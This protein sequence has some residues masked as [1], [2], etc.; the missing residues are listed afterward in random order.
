M[1]AQLVTIGITCFNAADTIPRAINSALRQDWPSCEVIIVDDCSTDESVRIIEEL[2]SREPRARLIMHERNKGVAVARNTI[3]EN[4]RGEFIAYFDDDDESVAD[5]VGQQFERITAYER[6][7]GAQLVFCY[8]NRNVVERDAEQSR[9]CGFAI[10]RVAPEPHGRPV[11]DYILSLDAMPHT[12]WGLCGSCTLMA[13]REDFITVG[14]FDESFRRCAEMDLAIRA[15]FMGGHFIAVDA[16][17]VT[18]YK[19]ESA[20]KAGYKPLE[21]SLRLREKHRGYLK[22]RRAYLSSR[23]FAYSDFYRNRGKMWK[24]TA[25]RIF[26]WLTSPAL[27]PSRIRRQ[28]MIKFER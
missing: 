3:I 12:A 10:G 23:A 19:T 26:A 27:M 1:T 28:V 8:S 16:P 7:S 2:I 5:R 21:Y 9:Q 4:A 11:A 25:Y 13:R 22:S 20:D 24:M 17:L 6:E 18:Q 15:A 14:L